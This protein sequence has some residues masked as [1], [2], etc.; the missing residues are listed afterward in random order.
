MRTGPLDSGQYGR[1]EQLVMDVSL[2]AVRD[3]LDAIGRQGAYR[4]PPPDHVPARALRGPAV[5]PRGR[6]SP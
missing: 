1:L 4:G 5:T 3:A 6:G 2:A